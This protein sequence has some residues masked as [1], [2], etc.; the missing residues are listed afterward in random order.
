MSR[1]DPIVAYAH[2]AIA[3]VMENRLAPIFRPGVKLTVIA[4]TPG[5]DD[6]DALVTNDDIDELDKLL[7]R[8]RGRQTRTLGGGA[9]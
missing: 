2:A 1:T 3:S 8:T 6:A 9:E 4:R 5:N 7:C